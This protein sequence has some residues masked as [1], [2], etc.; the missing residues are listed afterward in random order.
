MA[1]SN[2][3]AT[4]ATIAPNMMIIAGSASVASRDVARSVRSSKMSADFMRNVRSCPASSPTP[5]SCASI[6]GKRLL[7]ANAARSELP[8]RTRVRMR[9]TSSRAFG[10]PIDSMVS[11]SAVSNGAPP[12]SRTPTSR[13]NLPASA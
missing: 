4:K 2:D 10:S 1:C 7:S 13:A 5:T 3:N 8:S 11:S 9:A 12:P 6:G